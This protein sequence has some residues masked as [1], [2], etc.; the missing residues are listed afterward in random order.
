MRN[1]LATLI[2]ATT[3][4]AP[5]CSKPSEGHATPASAAPATSAPVLVAP[6]PAAASSAPAPAASAAVEPPTYAQRTVPGG[7]HNGAWVQ[8]FQIVRDKGNLGLSYVDAM[9]R[10]IG[11]G[12]VLCSDSS[13]ARACA[14]DEKLSKIETWVSTGVGGNRFVTRGGEDAGCRARDVKDGA[15]LSPTRAAVCCDFD[16]AV[17]TQGTDALTTGTVRRLFAYYRALRDKDALA[18]A[19]F[20]EDKVTWLGKEHTNADLIKVHQESFKK[21]PAQ[22]TQF[23]TCTVAGDKGDAPDAKASV[24][25]VTLFQRKGAV[26]VAMQRLIFSRDGKIKLIGD[27]E[28]AGLPAVSGAPVQ[29]KELKERVGILL[30]AD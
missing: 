1:H 9:S 17:K 22:W 11:Y 14:T 19:G 23:D 2:L 3:L 20:Y 8:P 29:E 6:P 21:D 18:L 10:C 30:Q 27:A 24:D 13:W 5:G 12:K 25:C 4:V 28:T 26:V 15:D 7:M 16:I